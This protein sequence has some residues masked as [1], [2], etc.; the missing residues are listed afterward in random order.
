MP[1]V[2][3]WPWVIGV[4]TTLRLFSVRDKV[5]STLKLPAIMVLPRKL[6]PSDLKT[7]ET[8]A[9]NAWSCPET[10]AVL[11]TVKLASVAELVANKVSVGIRL[12]ADGF[13]LAELEALLLL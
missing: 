4:P 2:G 3:L 7:F 8:V 12:L 13:E 1:S 5:P 6:W 11:S 9:S 10:V